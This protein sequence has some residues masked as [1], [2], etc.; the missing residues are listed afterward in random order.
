MEKE[1][2][3]IWSGPS[4]GSIAAIWTDKVLRLALLTKGFDPEN[5]E[6]L[7]KYLI[8]RVYTYNRKEDYYLR[9][10]HIISFDFD[11]LFM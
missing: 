9:N 10:V 4:I 7:K 11:K 3:D 2:K 1:I 6:F 5:T 8:R